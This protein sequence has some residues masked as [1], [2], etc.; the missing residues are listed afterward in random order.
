[1]EDADNPTA[2][3]SS[4]GDEFRLDYNPRDALLM[5]MTTFSGGTNEFELQPRAR[6]PLPFDQL[7]DEKSI[8]LTDRSPFT[9]LPTEIRERI[10]LLLPKSCLTAFAGVNREC[11]LLARAIQFEHLDFYYTDVDSDIVSS[12]SREAINRASDRGDQRLNLGPCICRMKFNTLGQS[13]SRLHGL[14]IDTYNDRPPAEREE[15]LRRAADHYFGFY[16]PCILRVIKYGLPNLEQLEF[17]DQ[18]ALS[19]N[20]W[21]AILTSSIRHLMISRVSYDDEIFQAIKRLPLELGRSLETL[22]L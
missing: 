18:I 14:D 4:I 11:R 2:R 20:A 16:I 13:F 17:H 9:L 1:M 8:S 6:P 5:S 21:S 10:V 19:G 22:S 7:G 15:A 12:L 3:N